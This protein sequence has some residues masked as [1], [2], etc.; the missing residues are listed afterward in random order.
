MSLYFRPQR[1]AA[2]LHQASSRLSSP[3]PVARAHSGLHIS[4]CSRRRSLGWKM[5]SSPPESEKARTYSSQWSGQSSSDSHPNYCM[6][7]KQR[8]TWPQR[9]VAHLRYSRQRLHLRRIMAP[10]HLRHL[11]ICITSPVSTR[12]PA[13]SPLRPALSST[14]MPR[15]PH[16]HAH[17]VSTHLCHPEQDAT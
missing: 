16:H 15:L 17:L 6:G 11:R 7:H 8:A 1:R 2:H 5:G 3:T 10:L 13:L 14:V 4:A 12:R 9:R